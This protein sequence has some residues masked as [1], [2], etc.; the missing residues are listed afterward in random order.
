MQTACNEYIGDCHGHCDDSENGL[1]APALG[2]DRLCPFGPTA[3]DCT[4]CIKNAF[5][6][7]NGA[8]ECM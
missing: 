3:A 5:R 8:C 6:N 7:E 2:G 4:R 1:P